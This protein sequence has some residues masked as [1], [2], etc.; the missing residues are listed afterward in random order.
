MEDGTFLFCSLKQKSSNILSIVYIKGFKHRRSYLRTLY[1]F[2]KHTPT[3]Y[4]VLISL[5]CSNQKKQHIRPRETHV[6][7]KYKLDSYVLMIFILKKTHTRK[8]YSQYWKKV[9]RK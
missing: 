9:R 7:L 1:V 2:P 4:V 6:T 8:F 5:R 3:Q